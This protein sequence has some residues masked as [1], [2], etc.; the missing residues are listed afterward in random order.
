MCGGRSSSS[1]SSTTADNRVAADNGALA[2]SGNSTVTVTNTDA[3]QVVRDV[4][5]TVRELAAGVK[6]YSTETIKT[7]ATQGEKTGD[8]AA[9]LA[10]QA[11]EIAK[12]VAWP[13][14]I[15][16]GGLVLWRMK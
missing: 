5:D 10:T 12:V 16:V 13:A 4:L 7:I 3:A 9:D 14:A 6:D 1:S 15:V 8:T 2:V 11:K